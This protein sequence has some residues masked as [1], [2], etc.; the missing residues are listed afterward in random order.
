MDNNTYM[1]GYI[2][3]LCFTAW[4]ERGLGGFVRV[5]VGYYF[6]QKNEY[7]DAIS[8]STLKKSPL[9]AHN[10]QFVNYGV[11]PVIISLT[12]LKI[13]RWAP[14]FNMETKAAHPQ[15]APV[16]STYCGV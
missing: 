8:K 12:L 16:H 13:L 7:V 6:S 1:R 10:S 14:S 5:D 4:G 9:S 2:G 3:K 11:A 15:G